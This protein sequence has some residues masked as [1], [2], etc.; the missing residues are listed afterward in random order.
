MTHSLNNNSLWIVASV[1]SWHSWT[2]SRVPIAIFRFN[3]KCIPPW[4]NGIKLLTD[5]ESAV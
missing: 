4:L 5:S 3:I 1:S 2:R